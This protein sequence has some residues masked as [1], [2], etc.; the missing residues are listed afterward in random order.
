MRII[1]I[2][3]MSFLIPL[4]FFN[5]IPT[6][7]QG[8]DAYMPKWF[9]C[10]LYVLIYWE[11]TRKIVIF[12]RKK[13]PSFEDTKKRIFRQ[14]VVLLVF[15]FISGLIIDQL[16]CQP[17]SP[18]FPQL[19]GDP[20]ENMLVGDI[21][22]LAWVAVYESVYF[23][24]QLRTSL[25]EQEQA[26]QE[27]IRSQL[28]GLRSQ[29]NPHFLFNSL[30]TLM[31]IVV[32]DQRLALRFLKKMSKVYRYMLEIREESIIPLKEELDFIQSYIFLIEERFRGNLK[33]ELNISSDYLNHQ[34]VP[35][36][37]QIL[38]ENAIKHNVISAKKMLQ[39]EVFI[40]EA[41]KLVVQ[42]NLQRK[43]QVMDSTKVG[44]DNICNRY[45]LITEEKVSIEETEQYFR[46]SLPLIEPAFAGV[47]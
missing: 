31:N 30:N 16:V 42:N 2:P 47:I 10:F 44:L 41:G 19:R 46:V 14:G 35:L 40:D 21:L 37:L 32:E 26:K 1:G 33:V 27:H 17:L 5:A 9:I 3:V 25:L 36:S 20:I 34:I 45:K 22:L 13:F 29:V 38:F 11:G 43:S 6:L 12:F 18:F 23:Y 4:I 15:A 39:V 24:H 8:L 7:L 28:E